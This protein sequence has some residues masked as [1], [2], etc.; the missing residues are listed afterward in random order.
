MGNIVLP[1][2]KGAKK[3]KS[4]NVIPEAGE[5]EEEGIDKYLADD[6]DSDASG[7][8]FEDADDEERKKNL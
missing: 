3:A 4:Y 1:G 5:G 2:K 7:D 8:F 6:S